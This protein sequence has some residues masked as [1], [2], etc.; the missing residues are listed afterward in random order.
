MAALVYRYG[1]LSPTCN[2]ERVRD[3][4]RIAHRYRNTLTEIERGL[5]AAVRAVE[6]DLGIAELTARVD[7]ADDRCA[8]ATRAIKAHKSEHRSAKP[9]ASLRDALV[10]AKADR[11]SA[12]AEFREARRR[13]REDAAFVDRV[14][15]VNAIA[16]DL[17]RNAR[18]HSG[19]ASSGP[20]YGAHGTYQLIESA[21]EAARG[22]LPLYDDPR[23]ARYTGEG[24]VGVQIQG[25][26]L[27]ADL[28]SDTQ[29]QILPRARMQSQSAR[30]NPANIGKAR[31]DSRR[32]RHAMTLRMRVGSTDHTGRE[33][34]WAEWPM[35]MHRPLPADARIMSAQVH[36][37][38]IATREEWHVTISIRTAAERVAAD[39]TGAVAINLGWRRVPDGLRVASWVG[40][41]GGAGEV[42]VSNATLDR[43]HHA[44][45][46]RSLRDELFDLARPWAAMVIASVDA[47]EWLRVAT[48]T[49]AAWKSPER[50]T[51]L[52]H[53]WS[54]NRFAGDAAAFAALDAWRRRNRHLWQYEAGARISAL[55]HRK[56]AYRNAAARL[57]ARYTTLV[58]DGVDLAALKTCPMVEA[59]GKDNPRARSNMHAASPGEFRLAAVSAFRGDVATVTAID[60]THTCH[61]CDRV[62]AFDASIKIWHRC[63]CGAL[64]DQDENAARNLL[65]RWRERPSGD[66]DAGTARHAES[67]ENR[68][69][70]SKRMAAERRARLTA[71]EPV[72]KA[73]E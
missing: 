16:A 67:L 50:L 45:S 53:R 69:A 17:R 25:G 64:W 35:V 54:Q 58:H 61:E 31:S 5:R 20:L 26:I 7:A 55:R 3:T 37:R 63:E 18:T 4:M 60:V 36:V 57:A 2:A 30:R 40:E 71:R 32:G 51:A 27:V 23:F 68:R 52:T 34:V 56:D 29:L 65:S 8:E 6:A 22:K 10:I 49:L 33:A 13:L 15:T 43:L 9:P 39:R 62:E 24:S 46:I 59:E 47:P 28:A 73:A 38:R 41:D 12:T 14:D 1:L 70:K 72:D 66:A 21:A 44:E 19:L 48:S 42:V 11:A